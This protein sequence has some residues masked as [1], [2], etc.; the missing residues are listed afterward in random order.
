M[1]PDGVTTALS[2]PGGFWPMNDL[3]QVKAWSDVL[4]CI[5]AHTFPK[6]VSTA[7]LPLGR[8]IP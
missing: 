3:I 6:Y 1:S 2:M 8:L 5:E 4:T 7:E